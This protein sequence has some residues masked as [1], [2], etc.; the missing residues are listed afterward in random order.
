MFFLDC[1]CPDFINV[2]FGGDE[3]WLGGYQLENQS[4]TDAGWQ[5]ITGEPWSY[6][7]WDGGEPNDCCTDEE[8]NEENYL[9]VF[10]DS[11][12]NDNNSGDNLG[13]MLVEFENCAGSLCYVP[14]TP[15]GCDPSYC[16]VYVPG[17]ISPVSVGQVNYLVCD[18]PC[19]PSACVVFVPTFPALAF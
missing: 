5:W 2:Y 1:F 13:G 16:N 10:D 11:T 19:P 14:C 3:A 15:G 12:W 8:N 6:T 18:G 7:N 4:A 17:L 9:M